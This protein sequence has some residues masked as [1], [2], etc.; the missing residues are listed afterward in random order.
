MSDEALIGPVAGPGVVPAQRHARSVAVVVDGPNR[1]GERR[2]VGSTRLGAAATNR[3][4]QHGEAA[5]ASALPSRRAR[6]GWTRCV[7]A[8]SKD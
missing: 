2:C 6:R 1:L 5:S 7:G 3:G 4:R 8:C